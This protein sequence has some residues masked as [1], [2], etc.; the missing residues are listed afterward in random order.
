MN[1]IKDLLFSL[2]KADCCG[3]VTE[4]S[5]FAFEFLSK[6]ADTKRCDNLTVIASLKGESDYTLM[7]DAHIDEVS[8]VVTNV[9]SEGFLTVANCGG[10]DL[11]TLPARRVTIH[12]NKNYPGVFCSIPPHLS[13]SDSDYSDISIPFWEAKQKI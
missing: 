7:L 2:C 4:T 11:R 5:D 12:S 10:C 13:S 3:N 6:Y 8:F 9:D 1:K